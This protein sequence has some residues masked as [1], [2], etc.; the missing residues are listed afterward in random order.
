[1]REEHEKEEEAPR[2]VFQGADLG[3]GEA[4]PSAALPVRPGEGAAGADPQL[5]PDT[6]QDL[7]P[8]PP[9]QDEERARRGSARP[10]DPAASAAAQGRRSDSGPGRE[11]VSH[12]LTRHG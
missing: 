1:M 2:F 12:L 11:T 10:G 8:E 9:L 5:D 6:G 7:V 3:T 4:L